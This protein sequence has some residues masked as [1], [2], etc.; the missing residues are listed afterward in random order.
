MLYPLAF[1]AT[2]AHQNIELGGKFD[3]HCKTLQRHVREKIL[4][5][6]IRGVLF[7]MR[8]VESVLFLLLET[9]LVRIASR[10]NITPLLS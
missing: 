2:L 7:E 1:R 10:A 8:R 4:T 3:E 9:A 6:N 5:R